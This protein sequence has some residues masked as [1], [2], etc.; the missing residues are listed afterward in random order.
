M[1]IVRFGTTVDG[2]GQLLL[3]VLAA[4]SNVHGIAVCWNEGEKTTKK[5]RSEPR[6]R[7]D[8]HVCFSWRNKL[9]NLARRGL[10]EIYMNIQNRGVSLDPVLNFLVSILRNLYIPT[11]IGWSIHT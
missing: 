3:A 6:D 1:E 8:G 11:P 4:W 2:K 9:Y 10:V 5:R 7:L